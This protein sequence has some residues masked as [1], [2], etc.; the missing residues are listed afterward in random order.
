MWGWTC[1]GKQK[2]TCTCIY[3]TVCENMHGYLIS[4]IDHTQ[5]AGIKLHSYMYVLVHM[6]SIMEPTG[7]CL[8]LL[9][10]LS[11]LN[12]KEQSVSNAL[13]LL[14]LLCS[15]GDTKLMLYYVWNTQSAPTT[16]FTPHTKPHLLQIS[17]CM[18][19]SIGACMHIPCSSVRMM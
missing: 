16:V 19:K 1:V 11:L 14:V 2:A 9:Q 5:W 17:T 8:N 4:I 15:N 13:Y 12:N 3:A 18:R 10:K 6:F 7:S